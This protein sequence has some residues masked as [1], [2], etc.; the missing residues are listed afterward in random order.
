[1]ITAKGL[2]HVIEQMTLEAKAGIALG[3]GADDAS[4]GPMRAE[5]CMPVILAH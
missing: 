1:M 5:V 2:T 4:T 3:S